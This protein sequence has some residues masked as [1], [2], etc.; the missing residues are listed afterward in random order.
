MSSPAKKPRP[1]TSAERMAA[2]RARKR[3]KGLVPRTIWV[4]DLNNPKVR[5]SY[6]RA[7]KAIAA[8]EESEREITG[9]FEQLEEW[10]SDVPEIEWPKK[11]S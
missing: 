8:A 4:P 7:A 5:E 11:K 1:K 3:A 2:Y 10:P 6:R 9:F